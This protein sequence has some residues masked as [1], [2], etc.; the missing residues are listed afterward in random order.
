MQPSG[1]VSARHAMS[2]FMRLRDFL[3]RRRADYRYSDIHA[4]D[5]DAAYRAECRHAATMGIHDVST[6][7]AGFD[8][9]PWRQMPL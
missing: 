7:C 4:F 8:V 3:R 2:Y 1:F 6:P 9:L 5:A